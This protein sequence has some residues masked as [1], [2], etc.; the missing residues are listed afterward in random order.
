MNVTFQRLLLLMRYVDKCHRIEFWLPDCATARAPA[1]QI[2]GVMFSTML[3]Q[4]GEGSQRPR[5]QV[6]PRHAVHA[7]SGLAA[8]RAI[9]HLADALQR[10][11]RTAADSG[12]YRKI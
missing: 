12:L 1:V 7:G 8:R 3:V 6:I 9:R 5:M 4:A 2:S 10:N 11:N